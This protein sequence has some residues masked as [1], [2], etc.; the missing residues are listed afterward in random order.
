ML[1][2]D[3][4]YERLKRRLSPKTWAAIKDTARREEMT[5]SAVIYEY[6]HYLPKRL[7]KLAVSCF[8]ASRGEWVEA[9]IAE[10]RKMVKALERERAP[11]FAEPGE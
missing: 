9:R 6:P 4:R 7:Q 3:E 2:V 5:L 8:V 1:I 10:L 11:R